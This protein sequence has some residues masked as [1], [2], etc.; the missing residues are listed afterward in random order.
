M[1][2]SLQNSQ[3]HC[4]I[5]LPRSEEALSL[6]TVF[7]K[8]KFA[9]N[10]FMRIVIN[11][12]YGGFSLSKEAAERLSELGHPM[13]I[14]ELKQEQKQ[15]DKTFGDY[16]SFCVDIDRNDHFL[17]RVVDELGR[18]VASGTSCLIDVVE[19]PDGIDWE[20]CSGEGGIEWVG[21]KHRRWFGRNEWEGN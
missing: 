17:L 2:R 13:A 16:E 4:I 9:E 6:L 8:H 11:N 19:I 20:V 5:E 21:E 15:I 18:R 12:D 10:S 14:E 7:L 1:S 3:E